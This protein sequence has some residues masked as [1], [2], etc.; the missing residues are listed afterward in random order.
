M[1]GTIMLAQLLK[2]VL[3]CNMKYILVPLSNLSTFSKCILCT[4]CTL[5]LNIIANELLNNGAIIL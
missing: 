3:Q 2:P 5:K 4:K 1:G